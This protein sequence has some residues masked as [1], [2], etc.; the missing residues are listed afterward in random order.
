MKETTRSPVFSFIQRILRGIRFFTG[1]IQLVFLAIVVF[2]FIGFLFRLGGSDI[3]DEAV[4]ELSLEGDLVENYTLGP[5]E[6]ALAHMS[7]KP[8]AQTRVWEVLEA[9]RLAATDPRIKAVTIK[10]RHL[11]QADPAKLDEIA[12]AIDQYR[13]VSGKPVMVMAAFLDQRQYY[14]SAHADTIFLHPMG[15]VLLEGFG[16]YNLYFKEALDKLAV[17]VHVFQAG[18]YKSAVEPF[19]ANGMSE[20][21]REA[22]HTWLDGLW[23]WYVHGVAQQRRFDPEIIRN[24]ADNFPAQ[25]SDS[26]GYAAQLAKTAGLVDEIADEE[27][28]EQFLKEKAQISEDISGIT[29]DHR[30]YM[31]AP[32]NTK[33]T[34]SEES[35]VAVIALSGQIVDEMSDPSTFDAEMLAHQLDR[36]KSNKHIKALVLRIDSPGGSAFAS[37]EMRKQLIELR[38]N[39]GIPIVVSMSG[40]TASGGYWLAMGADEIWANPATITG[41]IGVFG[42]MM[43]YHRTLEKLGLHT[44]GVGTT[45]MS[46]A[47]RSDRPLPEQMA[48]AIQSMVDHTYTMFISLVSSSRHMSKEEVDHVARGL[49][50]TGAQA[51]ER[52]LVDHT[53][54]FMDAIHAAALRADIDEKTPTVIFIEDEL[55]FGVRFFQKISAHIRIPNFKPLFAAH[56]SEVLNRFVALDKNVASNFRHAQIKQPLFL[57]DPNHLYTLCNCSAP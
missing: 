12:Q 26:G 57:N 3:P 27:T 23:D 21:T 4:L 37:E 10:L 7:G 42:L 35:Q 38:R 1:L 32:R 53:G 36:I 6:I 2:F 41:S 14:L 15:M 56:I 19:M 54:S 13:R 39:R 11:R 22:A 50:W 55:S 24:Y 44:D 46:G 34:G 18:K 45:S 33:Q 5:M 20:S 51:E 30:L 29:V 40:V 47:L 52:Q 8:H 28:F 16:S 9:L 31:A 43:T 49:V 48:V 17:D 25:L